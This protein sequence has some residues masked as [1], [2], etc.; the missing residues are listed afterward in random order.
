MLVKCIGICGGGK[1]GV[2]VDGLWLVYIYC[3]IGVVYK[4]GFVWEVV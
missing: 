1:F 4:G 2:L 3:W